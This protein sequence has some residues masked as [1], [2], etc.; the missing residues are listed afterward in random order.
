[1]N[2]T[3]RIPNPNF[4]KLLREI[5]SVLP[6][7]ALA[8][9]ILNYL[10]TAVI[11]VYSIPLPK[12]IA[13]PGALVLVVGRF[14]V[15][16]MDYLSLTGKRSIW[17]AIAA[18]FVTLF[19]LIELFYSLQSQFA[20]FN[21]FVSAY[22]FIGSS[23]LLGFVLELNFILKGM[24]VLYRDNTAEGFPTLNPEE[25]FHQRQGGS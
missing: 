16:F 11:N 14:M 15:V 2:K 23:I 17:P 9:I 22:C 21:H 12:Y 4:E 18:S 25:V 19:A 7:L 3:Q 1:M 24:D 5:Q 13:I 10:V 20:D 6:K 8:S